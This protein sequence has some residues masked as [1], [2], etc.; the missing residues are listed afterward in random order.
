MDQSK[1]GTIA[2]RAAL[3]Q[4]LEALRPHLQ[5]VILVGAQAVYLHTSELILPVAP[6]TLDADIVLDPDYLEDHPDI[7]LAMRSVGF[8]PNSN[9][10]AVGSWINAAGVPIDLM[11]PE[12]AGGP[13]RRA[14]RLPGHAAN[15]VRK[16]PG[17]ESV[18]FDNSKM[19]ISTLDVQGPIGSEISLSVAGPTSLVIAKLI[20]FGERVNTPRFQGKD[21]YDIYRLLLS[22]DLNT[23]ASTWNDLA[24]IQRL[25]HEVIRAKNYLQEH[26]AKSPASVGAKAAGQAETIIGQPELV[27]NRLWAQSADLLELI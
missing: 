6:F 5:S 9:G 15:S 8:V 26:F 10:G 3:L 24:G 21:A 4:G 23:L 2:A 20:K 14:A 22:G 12:S 1:Q 16:T 13:G 17:L 11:V 7:D 27:A 25:Q 19:L 18:L